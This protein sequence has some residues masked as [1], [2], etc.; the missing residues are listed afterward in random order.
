V[1]LAGM[2]VEV[3]WAAQE[4][5]SGPEHRGV[6]TLQSYQIFPENRPGNGVYFENRLLLS[7]PGQ[8]IRDVLPLPK[9]GRFAYLAVDA[10]GAARVDAF[11]QPQDRKVRVN[12]AGQG[13]FHL[14]VTMDDV[15]YKKLLR[16]REGRAIADL[17]PAYRTVDGPTPG[18]LGVAFYHVAT[19]V[20][21]D[22]LAGNLE[23]QFGLQ[24]HM[25]LY[26]EDAVRHY[27][28]LVHNA[29]PQLALA[30]R[31]PDRLAYRLEDGRSEELNLTQFQ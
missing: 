21:P 6:V 20:E 19:V 26:D 23:K 4:F 22:P 25:A 7:L 13:F 9:P 12:E 8:T 14:I 27:P 2:C 5:P 24:L 31:G 18:E 30:W 16:A 15:V 29:L 28:F 3:A 1:A 11:L 10:Q 17:L